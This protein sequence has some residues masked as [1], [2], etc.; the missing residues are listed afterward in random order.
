MVLVEHQRIFVNKKK[1][2]GIV[3]NFIFDIRFIR[4]C[5]KFYLELHDWQSFPITNLKPAIPTTNTYT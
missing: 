3:L 4:E 2:K 1:R 5:V